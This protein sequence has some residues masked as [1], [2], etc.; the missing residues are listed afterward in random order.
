M[1]G[2][3][4][5][6]WE[7]LTSAFAEVNGRAR[8]GKAWTKRRKGEGKKGWNARERRRRDKTDRLTKSANARWPSFAFDH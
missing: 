7:K 6:S 5:W 1:G 4:R 8:R 2:R 3:R